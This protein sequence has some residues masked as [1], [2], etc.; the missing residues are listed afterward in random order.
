VP[1]EIAEPSRE[2]GRRWA[3]LVRKYAVVKAGA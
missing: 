2:C 1:S 3:E